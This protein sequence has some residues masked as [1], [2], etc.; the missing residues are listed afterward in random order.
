MLLLL[1][2]A[3]GCCRSNA[4]A[5]VV[6]KKPPDLPQLPTHPVQQ[7]GIAPPPRSSRVGD[8]IQIEDVDGDGFTGNRK[9]SPPPPYPVQISR[10]KSLCIDIQS[11]VVFLHHAILLNV[12]EIHFF[13]LKPK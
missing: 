2:F 7:N 4:C 8:P 11:A 6:Q 10:K 13:L 3:F 1:S 9:S 12:Q 5:D